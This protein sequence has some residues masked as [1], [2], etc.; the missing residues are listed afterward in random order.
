MLLSTTTLPDFMR[1]TLSKA[2]VNIYSLAKN[3]GTSVNQIE[4]IY[5]RHLP[6]SAGVVR[7]LQTFGSS[8]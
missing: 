4:R 1:L 6:L 5:A 7:N 2:K 3:A 8:E